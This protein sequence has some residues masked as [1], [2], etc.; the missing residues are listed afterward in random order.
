MTP[1]LKKQYVG[2]KISRSYVTAC[3]ISDAFAN[4][5]MC[6]FEL[7]NI[8]I[9]GGDDAMTND[10]NANLNQST[11]KV[12]VRHESTRTTTQTTSSTSSSMYKNYLSQIQ[13]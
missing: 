6:N 10:Q 5:T 13:C 12:P 3:N 8:W 9:L 2:S 1:Y 11:E 4:Q 7:L